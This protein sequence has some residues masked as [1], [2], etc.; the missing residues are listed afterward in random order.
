MELIRV[1]AEFLADKG[2]DSPR[3]DAELLL[4]HVLGTSRLQL[5]LD[6]DRP[7]VPD[8][9][10]RYR[11]WVRRRAAREPLQL[12][13]GEVEI[14]DHRFRVRPGVFIPRP[15]TEVLI[16]H[17]RRLFGL[18]AGALRVV[19]VGVG[20]GCIGLSLLKA[21]SSA[22]LIGYDVNPLAI[23]LTAE[24]AEAL[25][26]RDRVE[27]READ[28]LTGAPL[29]PCD[30][31]VSNPPYVA[32]GERETLQPEVR[33]HEPESALFSGPDGLEAIRALAARGL[34]AVVEGGW[35]ALEHGADQGESAP[36]ALRTAGWTEVERFEDLGGRARV[37]IGRRPA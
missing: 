32:D 22:T 33:D 2:I 1:T 37:T 18:E 16:E 26:V 12:I 27:L 15:E 24:N 9:L 3:L 14:L 28:A 17:C 19:E 20:S 30:L 21:W 6:H 5:Y 8:E 4:A 23:A 35:I 13:L 11:E 36:E 25:G 34:E 7:I 10:A 31:L 29:P